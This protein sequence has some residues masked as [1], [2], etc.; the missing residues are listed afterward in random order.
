MHAR[1]R[2]NNYITQVQRDL[3]ERIA[4]ETQPNR[5]VQRG[6]S[7]FDMAQNTRRTFKRHVRTR[8]TR[9]F[10]AKISLQTSVS[11]N[12][13]NVRNVLDIYPARAT[14]TRK[15]LETRIARRVPFFADHS[16]C[17]DRSFRSYSASEELSRFV[18]SRK[19]F[20][21][22]REKTKTYFSSQENSIRLQIPVLFL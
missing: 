9:A 17:D 15:S 21:S 16:S 14:C 12:T 1:A 6:S 3:A 4:S 5:A 10:S 11:A 22:S 13:R 8:K 2:I 19:F 20:A 7:T 18:L